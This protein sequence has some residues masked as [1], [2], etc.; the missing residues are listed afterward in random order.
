MEHAE[1]AAAIWLL[2]S[3]AESDSAESPDG[4]PE[5]SGLRGGICFVSRDA[6]REAPDTSLGLHH[7]FSFAGVSRRRKALCGVRTR[8][9][10]PGPA[11]ALRPVRPSRSIRQV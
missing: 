8:A 6:A 4:S 11:G 10:H 5:H 7:G 2:R 9:A 1:L 3:R